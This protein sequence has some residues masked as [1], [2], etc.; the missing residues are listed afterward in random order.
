MSEFK[1]CCVDSC[2]KEQEVWK[3][4]PQITR[5]SMAIE[6][7]TNKGSDTLYSLFNAEQLNHNFNL[8]FD[9]SSEYIDPIALM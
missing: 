5:G 8:P 2:N 6:I 9:K 3:K 1:V 7:K 4:F